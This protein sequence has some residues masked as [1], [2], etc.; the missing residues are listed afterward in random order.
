MLYISASIPR[1]LKQ[2][3]G[4][5]VYFIIICYIYQLLLHVSLKK[6]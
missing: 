6:H 4:N 3:D 5:R 2:H 1:E